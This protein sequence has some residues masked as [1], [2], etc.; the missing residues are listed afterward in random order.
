MRIKKK[1]H[2]L[3]VAFLFMA[4]KMVNSFDEILHRKFKQDGKKI[5]VGFTGSIVPKVFY[6]GTV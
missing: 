6:D 2:A 3:S 4:D 5:W 1:G